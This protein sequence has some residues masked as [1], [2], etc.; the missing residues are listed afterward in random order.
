MFRFAWTV[1]TRDETAAPVGGGEIDPVIRSSSLAYTNGPMWLAVTWQDHED[2][3]AASV[4]EMASSDAESWRLAGRYIADLGDGMSVQISA[5]YEDLE[6]EF[7]GVS[8]FDAA[9]GAFGYGNSMSYTGISPSSRADV[10]RTQ[11]TGSG[12]SNYCLVPI[13]LLVRDTE[14]AA[15]TWRNKNW[16]M[17]TRY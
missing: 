7:N 15:T 8:N 10:F 9:M 12:S 2:W 1:G 11:R 14:I 5:M 17:N 13:G 6:Y 3:T 4:G 16:S